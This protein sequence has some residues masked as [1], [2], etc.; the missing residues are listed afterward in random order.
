MAERWFMAHR[1]LLCPSTLLVNCHHSH[2][3]T[4]LYACT[5]SPVNCSSAYP[6]HV[7]QEWLVCCFVCSFLE[8]LW[9]ILLKKNTIKDEEGEALG[10]KRMKKKSKDSMSWVELLSANKIEGM[11]FLIV[12]C[13]LSPPLCLCFCLC[14]KLS[15]AL[16]LSFSVLSLPDLVNNGVRFF[17]GVLRYSWAGVWWHSV[18]PDR[19]QL[20]CSVQHHLQ[21]RLQTHGFSV[22]L[23]QGRWHMVTCSEMCW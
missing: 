19:T 16:S 20:S 2:G 10:H 12:V 17:S 15:V 18:L 13:T 9:S 11:H 21:F 5:A 22:H 7:K 4:L 14:H 8:S 6:M 1:W 3:P 23:M